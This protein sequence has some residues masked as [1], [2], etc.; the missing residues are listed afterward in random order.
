[1]E[2]WLQSEV[3]TLKETRISNDIIIFAGTTEGRT[4]SEYLAAAGIA[5]TICVA[6]E[7]GELVLKEHP[8]VTVH[9]GRMDEEAM[10][11]YLKQ[12]AF[13]AVVDAT[14]PYATAVTE[15]VPGSSQRPYHPI[16]AIKKRDFRGRRNRCMLF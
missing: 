2:S 8:L 1:M 13:T 5:H 12:K 9:R 3:I 10:R 4:L 7:Y 15:N 16:S 6:T 14:H 11:E